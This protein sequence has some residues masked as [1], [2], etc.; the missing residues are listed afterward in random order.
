MMYWDGDWSGWTWFAMGFSMLLFW[1]VM[2][3]A[4]WLGLRA[5][6][7]TKSPARPAA[8]PVSAEDTLRQRYAEGQ[9]DDQEF[10]RRLRLLRRDSVTHA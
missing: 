2:A 3:G 6:S 7:T 5:V 4:I 10:N 8:P 9:I 1:S